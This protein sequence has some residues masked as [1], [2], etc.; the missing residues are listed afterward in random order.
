MNPPETPRPEKTSIATHRLATLDLMHPEHLPEA[1]FRQKL[2]VLDL[3]VERIATSDNPRFVAQYI[4]LVQEVESILA[5]VLEHVAA[6]VSP[7]LAV[8]REPHPVPCEKPEDPQQEAPKTGVSINLPAA[9][10]DEEATEKPARGYSLPSL[11]TEALHQRA[12]ITQHV[13]PAPSLLT[14][15]G[16]SPQK[17]VDSFTPYH[18]V[19]EPTSKLKRRRY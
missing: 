2:H 1:V 10:P 3:L 11:L 18:P 13:P 8:R 15:T 6:P 14:T 5:S 7:Y 16:R 4:T 17:T 19:I 12:S 9:P